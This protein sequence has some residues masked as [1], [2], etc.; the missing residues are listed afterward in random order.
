M[1]NTIVNNEQR[2]QA[3]TMSLHI[4]HA[5]SEGQS[6]QDSIPLP[7][8]FVF[9][10]LQVER[11]AERERERERERARERERETERER[12]RERDREKTSPK[13]IPLFHSLPHSSISRAKYHLFVY[14]A[15]EY[16][17]FVSISESTVDYTILNQ[18][19]R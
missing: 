19:E 13:T 3:L 11:N 15:V 12:Q 8:P 14:S 1:H 17:M 2:Q 9:F 6:C 10:A 18:S 4:G 7:L 16:K 5:L